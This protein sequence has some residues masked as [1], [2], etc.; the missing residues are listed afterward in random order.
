MIPHIAADLIS[1]GLQFRW[2]IIG[3]GSTEEM[4][5]VNEA[6]NKANVADVVV[7]LGIKTNPHYY[8]KNADL[9]VSLSSSEACPR[10]I[11]EAKIL[12][13]PVVCTNFDTAFEFITHGIDGFICPIDGIWEHIATI[14]QDQQLYHSIVEAIQNFSFDNASLLRAIDDVFL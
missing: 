10:V 8:I 2:F 4:V 5:V 14:M 11:N 6:I 9:L 1:K 12:G 13:T 3:G 7:Q